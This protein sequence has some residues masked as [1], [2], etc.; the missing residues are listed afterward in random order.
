MKSNTE[1]KKNEGSKLITMVPKMMSDI[2]LNP[3]SMNPFSAGPS[4]NMSGLPPM[5]Q[6][7][8][9]LPMNRSKSGPKPTY[10]P[11]QTKRFS[12]NPLGFMGPSGDMF[13]KNKNFSRGSN[14]QEINNENLEGNIDRKNGYKPSANMSMGVYGQDYNERRM[15]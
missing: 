1:E 11:T 2:P 8:N 7:V 13:D 5:G 3:F 6:Q 12:L 10:N 15:Y 14:G 4:N 9:E